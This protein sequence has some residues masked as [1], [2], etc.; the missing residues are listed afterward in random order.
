M[1]K[2]GAMAPGSAEQT[3]NAETT[4]GGGPLGVNYRVSSN[5]VFTNALY[6][7]DAGN[8]FDDL[9]TWIS[10]NI[11]YSRMVKAGVLP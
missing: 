10:P 11:L 5:R 4:L 7:D 1:G 3:E 6:R 8:Q 2:D 9:V